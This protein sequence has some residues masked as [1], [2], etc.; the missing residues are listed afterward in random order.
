MRFPPWSLLRVGNG[1][2]KRQL[3]SPGHLPDEV[4][5]LGRRIQLTRKTRPGVSSHSIP[6]Q[7]ILRRRDMEKVAPPFLRRRGW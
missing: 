2:G 7:G 5:F 1:S 6:D 4:G 3:V